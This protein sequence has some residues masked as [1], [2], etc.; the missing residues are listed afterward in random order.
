MRGTVISLFTGGGGLDIGFEERGF[1]PVVCVDNDA[2]SCKT[3]RLNRPAWGVFEGDIR[4]F[5][6]EGRVEGV[7][8]GPP[9]QGFSTAGKGKPNDPRNL[10]WQEYF[11]VVRDAAPEFVMFENVPGMAQ[12]K[13]RRHLGML[14]E[15]LEE[16]GYVVSYDIL[17]AADYGVPQIRRRLIVLGGRGFRIELPRPT[18]VTHLTV[19]E[20]IGDLEENQTASNHT[21]N[22][23]APHVRARWAALGPGEI[24]PGYR[25]ARLWADRPSSTIRAGGGYG[26]KGDHLA[27]FHPPIHYRF[28]RQ[29][30][31]REAARIQGFPDTWVFDGSKTA[32]GRQV[33]NAVPP[34]LAAAIAAKIREALDSRQEG[35]PDRVSRRSGLR[36]NPGISRQRFL[37]Y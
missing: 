26:P 17:N 4:D 12:K 10:L 32:Q 11:R 23:H 13:N 16:L 29:L 3:L 36:A 14:L 15:S 22:N 28:P 34:P 33:G 8:G 21:R 27:G 25:R 35:P 20:A 6:W 24:D 1:H 2:E 5:R 30:T 31:V 7:I 37:P 19:K 18:H 9:C